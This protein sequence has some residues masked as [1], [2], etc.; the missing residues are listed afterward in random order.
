M[1][2]QEYQYISRKV[3]ELLKATITSS[4]YENINIDGDVF[5]LEKQTFLFRHNILIHGSS[6]ISKIMTC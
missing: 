5:I 4:R 3:T 6:G 1:T 2:R